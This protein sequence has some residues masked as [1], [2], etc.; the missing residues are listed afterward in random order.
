[1]LSFLLESGLYYSKDNRSG[2]KHDDMPGKR[3]FH[4]PLYVK[5][6]TDAINEYSKELPEQAF[7][8]C[9]DV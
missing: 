5:N 1:V 2:Q 6:T 9:F 4:E 7:H 3:G 8:P